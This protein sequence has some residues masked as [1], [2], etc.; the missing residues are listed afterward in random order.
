MKTNAIKPTTIACIKTLARDIKRKQGI[1]HAAALDAAAN[2]SGFQNFRHA[3]NELQPR[4]SHFDM[5]IT[6]YWAD[7]KARTGGRE[8]LFISLSKPWAELILPSQ[9]DKC[10]GLT[11]FKG[12]A[13]DHIVLCQV[14]RGNNTH[15]MARRKV[16]AAARTM[17]FINA[18]KLRPTR[19]Y[20]QAFMNGISPNEMPGRDHPSVWYDK[21]TKRFLYVDEPYE[22]AVKEQAGARAAWAEKHGFSLAKTHMARHVW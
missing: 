17:A 11:K 9:L 7:P 2:Q 12:I 22:A 21:D 18:T 19:S 13:P 3:L 8:T 6:V 10:R 4:Q 15:G 20:R 14:L 1:K 16:C 5:Y